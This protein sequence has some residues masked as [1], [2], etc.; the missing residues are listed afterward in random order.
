MKKYYLH[1]GSVSRGPFSIDEIKQSGINPATLAWTEGMVKWEQAK[2]IPEL[3]GIF[4]VPPPLPATE[5]G[6]I[7][8]R[9]M[10]TASRTPALLHKHN[11][12]FMLTVLFAL[13]SVVVLFIRLSRP[14]EQVEDAFVAEEPVI[15][16]TGIVL[17]QSAIEPPRISPG[18]QAKTAE[19]NNPG[20]YLSIS[21]ATEKN[22]L[23]QPVIKGSVYNRASV[24]TYRDLK[25]RFRYTGRD[26]SLIGEEYV[27]I[28]GAIAPGALAE[29]HHKPAK[30][31]Y[32]KAAGYTVTV[33]TVQSTQ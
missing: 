24:T 5:E 15:S 12:S 6:G 33:Y 17:P 32:R 29:I 28:D 18:E 30:K 16:D 9:D 19:R 8:S 10:R 14:S 20:K 7:D 21:T 26:G 13:V 4:S 31:A 27:T 22:L 25:L 23:L 11:R 1:D 2:D 3:A